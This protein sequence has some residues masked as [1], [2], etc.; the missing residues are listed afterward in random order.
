VSL[1]KSTAIECAAS[2]SIQFGARP[3]HV[4]V[5]S[6]DATIDPSEERDSPRLRRKSDEWLGCF[7]TEERA[8]LRRPPAFGERLT[9]INPPAARGTQTEE[10]QSRLLENNNTGTAIEKTQSVIAMKGR[11]VASH[12]LSANMHSPSI[13]AV[14]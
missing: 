7:V 1:D 8:E 3:L 12:Q 4:E 5:P 11:R 2:T 14:G 6:R 10:I 9:A 13:A